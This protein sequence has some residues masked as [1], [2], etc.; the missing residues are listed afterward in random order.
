MTATDVVALVAITLG[1]SVAAAAVGSLLSRRMRGRSARTQI[2]LVA[3]TAVG[4][5]TAGIGIAAK[6][7]FISGHDMRALMIVMVAAA[8][9]AIGAAWQLGGDIT[10]STRHVRGI[11]RELV[12][13]RVSQGEAGFVAGPGELRALA[14]E[15]RD[16]SEQLEISRER[17]RALE[18]SRRELI[19][20]MSHDLRGPLATIRAMGE[21]LDDGIIDDPGDVARYHH[22]IRAD[23]ERLSVLVDDLFE[24]SRIH[25][26]CISTDDRPA[27]LSDVVAEAVVGARVGAELKGVVIVDAI[28]ELPAVDVRG[29]ELTRVLRNLLD[30]AVRHTPAGGRVVLEATTAPGAARLSV[31]DECGGIPPDDIDRVFD[32]AFRGDA[33]RVKDARGGGL[34]L[35]IARGLVEAQSGQISVTNVDNGCRFIVEL[36]V[37]A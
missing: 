21:A 10:A 3:I 29:H 33:A 11:A 37:S 23:S 22:Q 16:V 9:V 5:M 13:P 30:N 18:R 26:G 34:G 28:D 17:E 4:A 32:I 25:S 35:T 24:L 36:P 8:S 7:M 6:A 20:W 1:S 15:L 27:S 31:S 19:A 14:V 12:Q 2:L